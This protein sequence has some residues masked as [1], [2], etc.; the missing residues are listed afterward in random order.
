MNNDPRF[1][2]AARH[3]DSRDVQAEVGRA[4]LP[5]IL[6]LFQDENRIVSQAA[7]RS[8]ALRLRP[9]LGIK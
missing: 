1:S 5:Q 7:M 6:I 9:A 8:R 4:L 3:S 2:A